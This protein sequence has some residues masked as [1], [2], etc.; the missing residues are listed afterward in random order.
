MHT[1]RVLI[2]A[3]DLEDFSV[4]CKLVFFN[5]FE[6]DEELGKGMY[7]YATLFDMICM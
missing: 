3:T 1:C 5:N 2:T 7:L 4:N 6:D